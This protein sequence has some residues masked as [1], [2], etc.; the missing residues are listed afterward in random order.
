MFGKIKENLNNIQD[1]TKEYV[2]SSLEYYKLWVFKL[3]TRSASS[4]LKVAL[5]GMFLV[6][7]LVFLSI[8]GAMAIGY[9]LDNFVYGF[10]IVGGIYLVL[11]IVVYN[12][13]N[14]I[15]VPII[16]LFSDIFYNDDE[17]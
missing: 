14:R 13:K 8:A 16:R 5:M 9:A 12:L 17:D 4:L 2:E 6:M 7:V 10:L 3:I 11:S 1:Q 15:E